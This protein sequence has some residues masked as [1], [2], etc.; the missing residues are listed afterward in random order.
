[1]ICM[2]AQS[3]WILQL[4]DTRLLEQ[5][6][7]SDNIQACTSIVFKLG[8]VYV[9]AS[10]GGGRTVIISGS[11]HCKKTGKKSRCSPWTWDP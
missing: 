4:V 5:T 11:P 7:H 6:A 2:T 8:S 9:E 3:V 1:M 10:S